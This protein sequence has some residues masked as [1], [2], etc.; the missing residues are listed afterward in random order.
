MSSTRFWITR[1]TR[2]ARFGILLLSFVLLSS[3]ILKPALAQDALSN[4]G[5][6]DVEITVGTLKRAFILHVPTGYNGSMAVPLVVMLHGH[7]GTAKGISKVGWSEEADS[8]TFLVAY[9]QAERAK[10]NLPVGPGNPP[11]WNDGSN[12]AGIPQVDDIS[13]LRALLSKIA[14]YLKVNKQRIYLAGF[15]NGAA[16]TFHA[17]IAMS[18]QVA[19]I[20]MTAG[21]FFERAD[22]TLKLAHPMPLI[23]MIGTSDN[24][25]PLAGDSARDAI[26][27]QLVTST[28]PV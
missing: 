12:R 13:F 20:G 2:F 11:T 16:M 26:T 17:G 4:P 14:T 7:G 22:P 18:D 15:S 5:D 19:A 10:P 27:G 25:N 3:G 8:N 28:Q 21:A 23:Y 6:H 1:W 24:L 9:P